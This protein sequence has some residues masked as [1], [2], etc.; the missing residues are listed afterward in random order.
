MKTILGQCGVEVDRVEVTDLK[1]NTFYATIHLRRHDGKIL[2]V[3]ARPSD[4]IAL[5]L[6]TRAPIRVAK[7]VI[8]KARRIDLRIPDSPAAQRPDLRAS[9]LPA[10]DMPESASPEQLVHDLLERLADSAFGKWKM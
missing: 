8:D 1:E 2:P 10:D 6:R 7:K 5:A 3:D 4:A 9:A